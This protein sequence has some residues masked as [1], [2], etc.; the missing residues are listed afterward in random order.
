MRDVRQLF[1]TDDP[2]APELLIGRSDDVDDLAERLAAGT[3]VVLAGPRRTGKTSVAL[4]ALAR[5]REAGLYTADIDLWNYEDSRSLTRALAQA[6]VANRGPI[7]KALDRARTSGRDLRE[8]L[9]AGV[10]ATLRTHLG[11]DV[12]LAWS[13]SPAAPAAHGLGAAVSLG[14]RIAERDGK[15]IVLFFD[16]FQDIATRPH[17]FGDP[18][19]IGKQLRAQLQRSGLVSILFAG[20]EEHRMRDLFGPTHRALSQLG[21]FHQLSPILPGEW[22][23]GIDARYRELDVEASPAAVA[24]IVAL[25]EGQPRTTMLVARETLTLAVSERRAR[26]IELGDARGG[27]E[28]ARQAD[29]LRHEDV[30]ERLRSTNHAYAIALRLARGQRPYSNIPSSA[31]RRALE[32]MQ[33]SGVAEH[34][35]RGDWMIPD[36][37]LRA[38]L[39]ER[40]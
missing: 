2:V 35:G 1:P 14:Q 5:A 40:P 39:A 27:Y 21:S 38:Y 6:I 10:A 15:R 29:R 31:A 33:R 24:E 16:E 11:E 17:R 32:R 4:A 3:H 36:P 30:V 37:L 26:T 34:R 28:L 25:G 9:P 12:E 18:D 8:L 23:S 7:A 22:E 13:G 19:V 20:S